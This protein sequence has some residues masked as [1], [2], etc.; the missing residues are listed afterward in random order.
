MKMAL[1]IFVFMACIMALEVQATILNKLNK[2]LTLEEVNSSV[3][4]V[5]NELDDLGNVC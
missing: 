4:S 5:S 2:T 1:K 3:Q